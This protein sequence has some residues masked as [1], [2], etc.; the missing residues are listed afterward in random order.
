[1][2]TKFIALTAAALTAAGLGLATPAH[3]ASSP[4]GE[5]TLSLGGPDNRI[6]LTCLPTGGTHPTADE[7]CASL[8]AVWG[9]FKSLPAEQG[10]FCPMHYAPVTAE[11]HGTW[12]GN[13]V[14][15]EETFSNACVAGVQTDGVF[16]F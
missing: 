11:A 15:Y 14:D 1:M 10:V 13:P 2:R 9:R 5:L 12:A 8:T 6:S 3:A 4:I 16:D 7:A